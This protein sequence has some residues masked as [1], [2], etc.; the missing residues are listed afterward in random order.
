MDHA[1]PQILNELIGHSLAGLKGDL[2]DHIDE[3]CNLVY[4]MEHAP[5]LPPEAKPWHQALVNLGNALEEMVYGKGGYVFK[6]GYRSTQA[7]GHD[8]RWVSE[9]GGATNSARV[10]I[11]SLGEAFSS[12]ADGKP[13]EVAQKVKEATGGFK[14]WVAKTWQGLDDDTKEEVLT[15]AVGATLTTAV[16]LYLYL[17]S[18]PSPLGPIRDTFSWLMRQM[19]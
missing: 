19:R 18:L 4:E 15:F 9:G 2:G 3:I 7:R 1:S 13:A 16:L 12:L 17:G 8:G 11:A 14:E 10:P 5:D 6:A